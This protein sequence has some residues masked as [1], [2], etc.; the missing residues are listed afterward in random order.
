LTAACRGDGAAASSLL[1]GEKGSVEALDG[2]RESSDVS[3]SNSSSDV[4]PP[5][6]SIK[7]RLMWSNCERMKLWTLSASVSI[8]L[9]PVVVVVV[10]HVEFD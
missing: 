6:L 10:V 4:T 2:R 8:L 9:V 5:Y 7:H 1:H 3:E